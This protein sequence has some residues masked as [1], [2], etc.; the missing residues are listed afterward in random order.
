[1]TRPSS[2]H[3]VMLA[4]IVACGCNDHNQYV[5]ELTPRGQEVERR[6]TFWRVDP[7]GQA[8]EGSIPLDERNI[9]A[10]PADELARIGALYP[11]RLTPADARKHTFAGSFGEKLPADVGGSGHFL[12]FDSPLGSTN[13]YCERFRGEDDLVQSREERYR[14]I[15]EAVALAIGWLEQELGREQGFD[16]LRAFL[17]GQLRRDLRVISDYAWTAAQSIHSIDR[18]RGAGPEFI[19]RASQYL[20]ERGYFPARDL[21]GLV[22]LWNDQDKA[23]VWLRE[24]VAG[25]TGL[26]RDK[27]PKSLD[28]FASSARAESSL[29]RFFVKTPQYKKLVEQWERDQK[30]KPDLARP[31]PAAVFE[32]WWDRVCRHV[33]LLH[34]ADKVE[35]RL[36]CPS[37]PH[38]TN[39]QWD[40]KSQRVTWRS[41]IREGFWL[42]TLCFAAWSEP[43]EAA[44]REHFGGVVLTGESLRDYVVWY[45]GLTR[46]EADQWDQFVKSLRPDIHL[47]SK[48]KSFQFSGNPKTESMKQ[49]ADRARG[50]ILHGLEQR[51]RER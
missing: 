1:M 7:R 8:A 50:L 36:H 3:W 38:E 42:P 28:F 14:L 41:D 21:P 15:D 26:A 29:D 25:K 13:A 45:A 17:D 48:L 16:K 4:C 47:T 9:V 46:Q 24:F 33:G 40:D 10:F 35:V 20:V 39:G 49:L 11:K 27:P 23:L 18:G 51:Q 6:L 22:R 37:R 31:K 30:T 2:A 44:Q 19:A 12:R 43:K 34:I 5:V 32:E